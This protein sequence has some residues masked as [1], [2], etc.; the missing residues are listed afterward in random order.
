MLTNLIP[1]KKLKHRNKKVAEEP[2]P[3]PVIH[4]EEKEDLISTRFIEINLSDDITGAYEIREWLLK[5]LEER[6]KYALLVEDG[7]ETN[8]I[9]P[10]VY[11]ELTY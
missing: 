7:K 9:S 10:L 1:F 6:T 2:T 11:N 4:D 8:D 3:N 5:F